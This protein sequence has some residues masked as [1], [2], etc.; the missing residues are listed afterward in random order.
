MISFYSSREDSGALLLL[1]RN[2]REMFVIHQNLIIHEGGNAL[3]WNGLDP[4]MTPV[5]EG[6]YLLKLQIS[7]D[8]VQQPLLIGAI[9]P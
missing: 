5:P 8:S 1:D 9:S 4:D 2:G 7:D 3:V 6:Q